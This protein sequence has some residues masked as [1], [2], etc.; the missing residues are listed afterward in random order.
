MPQDTG[1]AS[2]S[3]ARPTSSSTARGVGAVTT[4]ARRNTRPR[5]FQASEWYT[6]C[7]SRGIGEYAARFSGIRWLVATSGRPARC[8]A[9]TT[10]RPTTMCA[11][12]CTTSGSI[13]AMSAA[14]A[15][16]ASQ[17]MHTWKCSCRK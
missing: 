6:G 14:V 12:V 9:R 5:S 15:G 13:S 16:P 8:A 3:P 10:P 4:S 2:G 7:S 1:N 17:G 11:W